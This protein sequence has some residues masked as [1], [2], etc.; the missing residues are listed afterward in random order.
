M[1]QVS[2]DVKRIRHFEE[3]ILLDYRLFLSQCDET[4]RGGKSPLPCG[5]RDDS[6][7]GFLVLASKEDQ[8]KGKEGRRQGKN[9]CFFLKTARSCPHLVLRWSCD[10]V[11]L[12]T[13]ITAKFVCS[14]LL[15]WL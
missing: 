11:Y 2:K 13:M 3:T 6:D 12:D 4:I 15:K 14:T 9:Q 10:L 7:G 8:T 1:V 5:H